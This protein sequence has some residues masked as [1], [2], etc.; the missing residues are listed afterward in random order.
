[1]S[2]V[3]LAICLLCLALVRSLQHRRRYQ[4][5]IARPVS[6]WTRTHAPEIA[7][8]EHPRAAPAG[9]FTVEAIQERRAQIAAHRS[10]DNTEFVADMVAHRCKVCSTIYVRWI[11]AFECHQGSSK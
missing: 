7:S 1:M 8:P 2:F 11:D 10:R 6:G 4:V 3:V 5:F 9:D